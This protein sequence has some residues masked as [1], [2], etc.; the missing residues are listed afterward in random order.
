M[1]QP[2]RLARA[3]L[4]AASW[5]APAGRRRQWRDRREFEIWNWWA[6]LA[7]RGE[8]TPRRKREIYRHCLAAFPD[9]LWTRFDREETEV[10]ARR[11][12]RGPTAAL[13]APVLLIALIAAASGGFAGLR[14][15]YSKLPYPN[16]DE[17]VFIIQER[18]FG[19]PHSI[20]QHAYAVWRDKSQSFQ[21]M[22]GF[23]R[24]WPRIGGETGHVRIAA[25]VTPNFLTLLGVRPRLGRLLKEGDTPDVAVLTFVPS[26]S[27]ACCPTRSRC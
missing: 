23:L 1:Q 19:N 25:R 7:E 10:R 8:L 20:P 21:G 2:P 3:I 18:A 17:L 15:F 14:A 26:G 12:Y 6:L 5:L 9:A 27:S 11:F 13:V 16:P 4:V 22:A 24:Y